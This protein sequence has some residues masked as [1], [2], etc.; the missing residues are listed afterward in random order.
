TASSDS[1]PAVPDTTLQSI[2]LADGPT[3]LRRAAIDLAGRLPTATETASVSAGDD[4]SLDAALDQLMTE[5]IFF[6]R[7]REIFND[8]LLTDEFL[9]YSGR[10]I[11]FTD[12]NFYPAMAPYRDQNNPS[13][14]RPQRPLINQALAREPL[15]LIAYIVKNGKPFTDIVQGTYTVV[16]PF[17]AIAYGLTNTFTFQDPTNYFEF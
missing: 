11:D 17:S 12:T 6:D 3:T 16:N 2:T 15:D 4:A 10:A 8:V 5:D 1:C 7:L 9:E 14:M 13:Y